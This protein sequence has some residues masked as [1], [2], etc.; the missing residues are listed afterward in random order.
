MKKCWIS[1]FQPEPTSVADPEGVP[2][3]PIFETKIFRFNGKFQ[4]NREKWIY[5]QVKL[6]NQTALCKFETPIKKSWI[7]LLTYFDMK[8]KKVLARLETQPHVNLRVF[9]DTQIL[10]LI[11]KDP[12]LF[13]LC[14]HVDAKRKNVSTDEIMQFIYKLRFLA[15]ISRG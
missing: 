15:Q 10:P 12:L 13:I 2:G 1:S 5:Y 3:N 7:R 14:L 4:K 8:I 6:T 9:P 11:T